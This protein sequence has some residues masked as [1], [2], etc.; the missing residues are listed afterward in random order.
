MPDT[1]SLTQLEYYEETRQ[2]GW[3]SCFV[4]AAFPICVWA[5]TAFGFSMETVFLAASAFTLVAAN[6]NNKQ[7]LYNTN[8]KVPDQLEARL[9][10]YAQDVAVHS[11]LVGFSVSCTAI[12]ARQAVTEISNH[13]L[14]WRA[15]ASM[16]L[17]IGSYGLSEFAIG[18]VRHYAEELAT[19][20]LKL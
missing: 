19:N 18:E 20:Q 1:D 2:A 14:S 16:V 17:G 7:T 12:F 13:G 8:I 5:G 3:R 15:A 10:D 4:G 11:A 6:S 9:K